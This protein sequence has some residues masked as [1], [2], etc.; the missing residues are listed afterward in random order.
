MDI[1][2]QHA[3]ALGLTLTDAQLDQFQRFYQ[4]LT[5]WNARF[6]LTRITGYEDVQVKH[7]LDSLTAAAVIP[8]SVKGGGRF[9]DIGAG[10]GLPGLALK[11]AFPAIRLT[12]IEAT[13]KKAVFLRHVVQ[14]LGLEGVDVEA[15]RS[16]TLAQDPRYRQQF[17][18]ALARALAPMGP[19]AE[20]AL[21]FCNTGGIVVA[22]KKGDIDNELADA[23]RAI[24]IVGGEVLRRHEVD[25]EGL[26]DGR[27]LVVLRK[28]RPTPSEYPRRPGTPQKSPI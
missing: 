20:M 5:D 27:C 28:V 17:D 6:N 22:Y 13:G 26:R 11:I 21:P 9:V 23:R 2:R 24:A 8:Q 14:T 1:L 10:A 12:L 25:I 15:E 4:E 18:V 16:E 7:F 19:L 3:P